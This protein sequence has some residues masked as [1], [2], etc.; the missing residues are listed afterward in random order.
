MDTLTI[1]IPSRGRLL[2]QPSFKALSAANI[3]VQIVVPPAELVGYASRW[4]AHNVLPCPV[5]GIAN[6]RQW[7]MEHSPTDLVCMVDDDLEFFHRKEDDR[8]KLRPITDVELRRA[9]TELEQLLRDPGTA[10]AGLACREG[11]NRCTDS[12]IWNTRILRVLAYDRSKLMR[13]HIAFGRM[14]VMED[15][16]VALRLLRAGYQNV[17]RN[18]YAHNQGGSG[19][20]GGCSTYRTMEVQAQAARQLASLHPTFVKIVEKTTK[21]AWGGG[22]RTDVQISWKKAYA[23]AQNR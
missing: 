11:A 18:M 21:A 1:Y 20:A 9:F 22:T 12:H 10:H 19:S 16:D 5:D 14:Q 4:G 7:I 15:F 13:E 8:A 2:E 3:P 17:V 23:S 6:T